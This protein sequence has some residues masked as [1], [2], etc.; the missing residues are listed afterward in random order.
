MPKFA[1]PGD[2]ISQ[3]KVKVVKGK[4]RQQEEEEKQAHNFK[5]QSFPSDSPDVLYVFLK[6]RKRES[7]PL[8]IGSLPLTEPNPFKLV[9]DIRGEKY[10]RTFQE[11]LT[12]NIQKGNENVRFH[13]TPTPRKDHNDMVFYTP[14]RFTK[15]PTNPIEFVFKTDTR[16]VER[17]LFDEER[18]KRDQHENFIKLMKLQE[19]K[20]RVRKEIRR[21]RKLTILKARPIRRYFPIRIKPSSRKPT[22]PISP[23]IGD[24]RRAKMKANKNLDWNKSATVPSKRREVNC[25]GIVILRDISCITIWSI[26]KICIELSVNQQSPFRRVFTYKTSILG[27]KSPLVISGS[28]LNQ[29]WNRV[30]TPGL[31][32]QPPKEF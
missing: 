5:V 30:F 4:M 6:N 10:Q 3:R 26:E 16:V 17:R 21:L 29:R 13:A 24:K 31:V 27:I 20:E 23:F 19:E 1:L 8:Q 2:K 9:T 15:L 25:V 7:Q 22:K 32:S 28:S 11:T 12:K 18:K 14:K